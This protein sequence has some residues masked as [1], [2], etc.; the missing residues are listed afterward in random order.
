MQERSIGRSPPAA[1]E[2][3]VAQRLIQF[4]RCLELREESEEPKEERKLGNLQTVY[5]S[6]KEFRLQGLRSPQIEHLKVLGLACILEGFV[7]GVPTILSFLIYSTSGRAYVG[8]FSAAPMRV[9]I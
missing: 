4:F 3:F 6:G 8:I 5:E 7:R 2:G 9:S 1:D